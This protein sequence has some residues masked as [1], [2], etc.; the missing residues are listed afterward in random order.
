MRVGEAGHDA[1]RAAPELLVEVHTAQTPEDADLGPRALQEAGYLDR[2]RRLLQLDVAA[3]LDLVHQP[4]DKRRGHDDA[5]VDRLVLYDHR[6]GDGLG[7]PPVVLEDEVQTSLV[8]GRR[9]HDG[10]RARLLRRAGPLHHDLRRYRRAAHDHRHAPADGGDVTFGYRL[11][12]GVRE[13]VRFAHDPE[14]GDAV[15]AGVQ[16][17][18]GERADALLVQVP[19]VGEGGERYGADAV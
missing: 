5:R 18:L 10:C 1:H 15:D 6:H 11:P 9:Y 2:R 16:V 7:H 8:V 14:Y 13:L 19:L 3:A 17:E 12:L 4:G